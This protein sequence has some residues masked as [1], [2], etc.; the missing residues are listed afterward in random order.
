MATSAADKMRQILEQEHV[1]LRGGQLAEMPRLIA[2]KEQAAKLLASAPQIAPAE[3]EILR[4]LAARNAGLLTAVMS[5]MQ[6]GLAR[7]NMVKNGTSAA[8]NTYD[9]HGVR[10]SFGAA[11]NSVERR[12]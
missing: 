11:G 5:G 7:L 10:H 12:A 9:R 6:A 1:A 3:A 2:A 8:L 4:N